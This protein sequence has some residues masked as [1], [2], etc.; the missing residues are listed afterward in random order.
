MISNT[1]LRRPAKH[2]QVIKLDIPTEG[3]EKIDGDRCSKTALLFI[4]EVQKSGA[5]IYFCPGN[6]DFCTINK[7]GGE[8]ELMVQHFPSFN[9]AYKS[10][11]W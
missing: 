4:R 9:E 1:N 10:E 8:S 2:Y 11:D 6:Y 7:H 3:S 5:R